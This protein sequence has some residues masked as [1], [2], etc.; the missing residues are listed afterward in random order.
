MLLF[1]FLQWFIFYIEQITRSSIRSIPWKARESKI[2]MQGCESLMIPKSVTGLKKETV[3]DINT[4]L[5]WNTNS[6]RES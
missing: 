2:S 3:V 4:L 5:L 6:V 1:D